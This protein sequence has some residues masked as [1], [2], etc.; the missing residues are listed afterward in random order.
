[1]KAEFHS[2]AIKAEEC[3]NANQGQV[4]L[5]VQAKALLGPVFAA[6]CWVLTIA[7]SE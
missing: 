7:C 2:D 5:P 1:M 3:P 4:Q 6:A